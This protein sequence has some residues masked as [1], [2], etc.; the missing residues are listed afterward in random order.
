MAECPRPDA[1]HRC[2]PAG[3]RATV[4][5]TMKAMSGPGDA[6]R[7]SA[8]KRNVAQWPQPYS[9]M[10]Q[11]PSRGWAGTRARTRS[12]L[13]Q[14]FAAAGGTAASAPVAS[15]RRSG[16]SKSMSRA[17]QACSRS[18]RHGTLR[19]G[20]LRPFRRSGGGNASRAAGAHEPG[21]L[22]VRHRHGKE[23]PLQLVATKVPEND[24]LAVRFNALGDRPGVDVPGER[25]DRAYGSLGSTVEATG[26]PTACVARRR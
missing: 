3:A 17:G 1:E 20:R 22:F 24:R 21:S 26:T 15:S 16:V 23:V 18:S 13:R 6:F 12:R 7:R 10:A 19:F 5:P 2:E 9:S 14:G 25:H 8:G 4:W 11:V